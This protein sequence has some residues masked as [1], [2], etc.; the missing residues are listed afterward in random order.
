ML[1][2]VSMRPKVIFLDWDGTVSGSR[3]WGQWA[4]DTEHAHI[5]HL[6]QERFFKAEPQTVSDWMRG[7]WTA[8]EITKKIGKDISVPQGKL[9]NGLRES[10][11][12]MQFFNNSILPVVK[13]LRDNGA[14]VVVATDNMDTFTRWTAPALRL[15]HHFDAILC[16]H[17][18]KALKK[19]KNAKG[20]SKF[21]EAFLTKNKI[22]PTSTI[23]V[24][25]GAHNAVV[26]DFGMRFIQVTQQSPA[27]SILGSVLQEHS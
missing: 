16:S 9:L 2:C 6:I 11:R 23:L 18:L 13:R 26:K 15:N 8:E 20:S 17:M 3:F 25:D 24:D 14:M 10:C 19:D 21:F 12:Q 27:E 5:Y 22:D 1:G 4:N 7:N